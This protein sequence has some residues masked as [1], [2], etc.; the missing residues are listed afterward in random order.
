MIRNGGK[1][2]EALEGAIARLEAGGLE[3][4]LPAC[5]SATEACAAIERLG[6]EASA[7]VVAGGDGTIN[8]VAPSLLKANRPVGIIPFGTANDLARTLELP[9][10][11]EA[12]ADV[13]VRGRVRRIDVG[14]ANGKPFFNVATIGLGADIAR[15][16]QGTEK[17]LGR[18]AY[19]LAALRVLASAEPFPVELEVDGRSRRLRSYQVAVGNGR[20]HGGGIAVRHDAQIDDGLLSLYS[21][22]PGSLWK[23]VALAPLFRRG[24]HVQWREVETQKASDIQ[25]R[26]TRPHPVN[27][28][29][30]VVTATPLK[31]SVAR[32][33]LEVFV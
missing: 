23:A 28:D 16:L 6:G 18:A 4:A 7:V 10:E 17:R 5:G 14:L 11:P 21:L 26:T 13:I 9:T 12:A 20:Y 33:A 15:T 22:G 19:W 24:R 1:P 32:C 31:L 27:L 3:V 25:I 29:G 8:A 2:F 30:D